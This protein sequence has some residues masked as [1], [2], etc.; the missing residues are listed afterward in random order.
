MVRTGA[1]TR[2]LLVD[3]ALR[4]FR[5]QGFDGTTMRGIAREAGVSLGSSYHY[6]VGK[7]EL[8]QELY[9]TVQVE[10]RERA[11]ARIDPGAPLADNLRATLHAGI[12]VMAPYHG[13]GQAFLRV[14][15]SPASPMSPFSADSAE[16]RDQAVDLMRHV[17]EAS[18]TRVPARLTGRLPELL[19]LVYLG[20]T[21]HWVT[22]GTPDQ[23][24]TRVLVD[25][26]APVVGRAV[27]LSRLP[28]ARRLLD[29]VL[30]LVT[31]LEQHPTTQ[32][33]P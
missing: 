22:D 4:L 9:R 14:A 28:V 12:D 10:H 21:L 16:P 27:A 13:F 1:E 3:T 26:V 17:V 33:T 23:R 25:G 20:V 8:V 11:T 18:G 15:L 30:G 24:R 7:D 2:Q 6:F 19:W 31:R 29:D 32:E 5:E